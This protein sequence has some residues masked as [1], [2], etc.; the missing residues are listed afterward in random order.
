MKKTT[1]KYIFIIAILLLFI[2]YTIFANQYEKAN[3]YNELGIKALQDGE[4]L[5]AIE[6]LR[7][8]YYI[9]PENDVLK[10]NLA[11]AYNN[12]AIKLAEQNEYEEAKYNLQYAIEMSPKNSYKRNLSNILYQYAVKLYKNG[13]NIPAIKY[14]LESIDAYSRNKD[15]YILLGRIYYDMGKLY[16]AR[17]YW[18]KVDKLF[19]GDKQISKLLARL[20]KEKYIESDYEEM[21]IYYFDLRYDEQIMDGN[22][23]M[24]RQILKDARRDVGR[25]YRYYPNRKIPV[26]IYKEED[27]DFIHQSPEW[28]AAVYDGKIRVP[29]SNNKFEPKKF[30]HLIWHEYSHA[31]VFDL[32]GGKCPIWF[33]EGLAMYQES[34]KTGLNMNPF[35]RAYEKNRLIPIKE[36]NTVFANHKSQE[37]LF[38]AYIE[39]YSIVSYFLDRWNFYIVNEILEYC[40]KGITFDDALQKSIY[41]NT[42][43]LEEEC[44]EYLNRLY[45]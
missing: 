44:K 42:A 36:L 35:I 26:I 28:V 31:L 5:T 43:Q 40:K 18:G 2:P 10:E 22:E 32:S 11:M 41:R 20:D 45:K 3:R 14:L 25:D 7:D 37:Q 6:Y 38:L 15:A 1:F 19:P 29:I 16:K 30:I 9:L 23:Y 4:F 13:D 27:F 8:A 17:F 39:S 24:L 21:D 34:K 33:N 12:Y